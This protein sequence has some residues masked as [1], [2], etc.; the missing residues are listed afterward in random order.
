MTIAPPAPSVDLRELSGY[1]FEWDTIQKPQ[2]FRFKVS[3]NRN[4][5]PSLINKD[6][7]QKS[8]SLSKLELGTYYWKVA[9]KYN[10]QIPLVYSKVRTLVVKQGVTEKV[11]AV[12]ERPKFKSV[13]LDPPASLKSSKSIYKTLNETTSVKLTWGA[14]AQSSSYQLEVGKRTDVISL[15]NY[16]FLK[17]SPGKYSWRVRAV[18]SGGGFGPWSQ[19]SSFEIKVSEEQIYLKSPKNKENDKDFE[20]MFEWEKNNKC[21]RY[22]LLVAEFDDFSDVIFSEKTEKTTVSWDVDD[23]GRYF[24]YVKCSVDSKTI[25]GSEVR[26]LNVYE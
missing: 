23:E 9:A 19:R 8:Y 14:V 26:E 22:E 3:K 6:L 18:S 1:F 21:K 11:L 7:K 15:E 20:V 10:R 5:E 25:L 17:L 2:Y 12:S 24:W 4:F 13:I 16:T